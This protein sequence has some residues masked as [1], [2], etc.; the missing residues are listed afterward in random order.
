[1][2]FP[3]G[4]SH[5]EAFHEEMVV[6]ILVR[7]DSGGRRRD[8]RSGGH[9]EVSQFRSVPI[10]T[11]HV[12][13]EDAGLFSFAERPDSPAVSQGVIRLGLDEKLWVSTTAGES[14][15]QVSQDHVDV[16]LDYGPGLALQGRAE[17]P[18]VKVGGQ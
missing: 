10:F 15:S 9:V 8:P 12:E 5:I 11:P 6:P 17:N 16:A 14:A 3:A 2:A 4:R 7:Q 18:P 1:M 13:L